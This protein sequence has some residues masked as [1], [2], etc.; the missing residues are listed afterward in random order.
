MSSSLSFDLR[1][2]E[3]FVA[4]CEGGSMNDAARKL[5]VTQSA[6][7]QLIKALEAQSGLVLFDRDFRPLRPTAAG[8]LLLDLAQD[9]LEHARGVSERL[10][11]AS[12]S[13]QTQVRLGCVDSFGA[14]VGAPLVAAIARSARGVT[15]WS[16]LTPGLSAQLQN[17]ELDLAVCTEMAIENPRIAHRLLCTERFIAVVPRRAER[18]VTNYRNAVENLPLLRYTRRSVIGQQIERYIRHIGLESPRRMEFDASDPLLSLV[19]AGVGYAVTTPLCLW[20]SRLCLDE[21]DVVNLPQSPLGARSFFLLSREGEWTQLN[22]EIAS[23]SEQILRKQIMPAIRAAVPGLP[24][25]VL[26]I[27]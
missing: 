2:L 11:D 10:A 18:D 7:S 16:G 12:R 6:I 13:H 4:V 20:Q 22:D 3:A 14:T 26:T 21:V 8:R 19:G 1:S 27:A 15:L 5:G 25:D 24:E 9:L 23:L 17:R